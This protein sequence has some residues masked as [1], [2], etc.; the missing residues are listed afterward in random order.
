MLTSFFCFFFSGVNTVAGLG[1]TLR[2]QKVAKTGEKV[3]IFVTSFSLDGVEN[4]DFERK[5]DVLVEGDGEGRVEVGRGEGGEYWFRG[6]LKGIY[7]VFILY[8]YL[9][10]FCVY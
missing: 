7:K 1:I 4:D 2:S 5:G 10:I 3:V 8:F 6:G 9:F